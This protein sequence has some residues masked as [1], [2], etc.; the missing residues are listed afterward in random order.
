MVNGIVI[1]ILDI[2]C[3]IRRNEFDASHGMIM[4]YGAIQLVQNSELVARS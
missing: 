4:P 3:V 2:C 1:E